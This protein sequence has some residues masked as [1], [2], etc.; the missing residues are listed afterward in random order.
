MYE[1]RVVHNAPLQHG[2][3]V[4]KD[5][6]VL[7]YLTRYDES[8][9]G[10]RCLQSMMRVHQWIP[11]I[12]LEE[13]HENVSVTDPLDEHGCRSLIRSL[14]CQVL[15]E[16]WSEVARD[17][18]DLSI[19]GSG[20]RVVEGFPRPWRSTD[21]VVTPANEMK[22]I[23]VGSVMASREH[24]SFP[25]FHEHLMGITGRLILATGRW[26]ASPRELGCEI[27][28]IWL[29]APMDRAFVKFERNEYDRFSK[30]FVGDLE[31]LY[32]AS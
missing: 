9:R 13:M 30:K 19:V 5:L 6:A 15:P 8:P 26:P 4:Q 14:F 22:L 3:A 20:I 23:D 29:D 27:H 18:H 10:A 24:R 2:L 12:P 17:I 32:C 28:K 31:R 21:L 7:R 16:V 25:L 11:G 1:G